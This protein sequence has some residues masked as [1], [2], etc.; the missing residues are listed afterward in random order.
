MAAGGVK[1]GWTWEWAA[2]DGKRLKGSG[3]MM[4]QTLGAQVEGKM[5]KRGKKG[6]RGGKRKRKRR[7][8]K[9]KGEALASGG[10]YSL[11]ALP[12]WP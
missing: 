9:P 3:P 6:E 11:G 2:V 8:K 7:R 1:E 10:A 5:E 4:S 12:M